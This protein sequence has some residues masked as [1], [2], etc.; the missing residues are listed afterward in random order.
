MPRAL[1]LAVFSLLAGVLL[2]GCP[3]APGKFKGTDLSQVDW[4]ADF[5]LDAHTGARLD[6]AGYR[7]KLVVLFFG[8]THCPDIC[9]PTLAKL[10]EATRQLGADAARVQ[11]LFVSV[12]PKHDTPAQLAA[13]V[14]K[15]HPSFIGLTGT[16]AEVAAVARE[17]KVAFQSSAQA[18]EGRTL[19]DHFGGL[20]VKDAAGKLRL[21]I[22]NDVPV[23]DITHDLRLLL[24]S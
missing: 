7:G 19:V 17:Y 3:P 9:A 22:R 18:S 2:A 14:P 15:F 16:E 13:F 8:Y 24:K 21:T 23:A 12:D 10:A 4:G 5:T 1:Y 11:V 6:T 20:M